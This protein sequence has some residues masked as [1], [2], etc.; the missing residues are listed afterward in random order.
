MWGARLRHRAPGLGARLGPHEVCRAAA[1]RVRRR[2]VTRHPARSEPSGEAQAASFCVLNN[3]LLARWYTYHL[4]LMNL[5]CSLSPLLKAFVFTF[6]FLCLPQRYSSSQTD[7]F[8]DRYLEPCATA[9]LRRC[10]D[11]VGFK[12]PWQL[13]WQRAVDHERQH[14]QL[15]L[16]TSTSSTSPFSAGGL[17]PPQPSLSQSQPLSQSQSQ[18]T[19]S[20]QSFQPPKKRGATLLF[21]PISKSTPPPRHDNISSSLVT[22]A[23]SSGGLPRSSANELALSSGGAAVNSID[24]DFRRALPDWR[25]IVLSEFSRD[26]Q[27]AAETP[28]T[29]FWR[30]DMFTVRNS[31]GLC[32]G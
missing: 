17:T 25:T 20:Q 15:R 18:L 19:Q 22:S 16:Q 11:R 30:R 8:G 31:F 10:L 23:N 12:R 21:G 6:F 14:K 7:E 9:S 32:L 13:P 27:E 28:F 29:A 4:Q 5:F 26:E 24:E 3:S 1:L 2:R